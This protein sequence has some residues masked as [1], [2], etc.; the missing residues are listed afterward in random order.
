MIETTH[1]Q[2]RLNATSLPAVHTSTFRPAVTLPK[3]HTQTVSGLRSS[4]SSDRPQAS[5]N[6]RAAGFCERASL[7]FTQLALATN[8]QILS[9]VLFFFKDNIRQIAQQWCNTDAF[10][11]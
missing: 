4:T 10:F 8:S 6:R 1:Y 3:S 5:L 9:F 2:S 11:P 7:K